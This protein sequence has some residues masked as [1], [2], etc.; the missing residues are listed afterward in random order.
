MLVNIQGNLVQT[1]STQFIPEARRGGGGGVVVITLK[2]LPTSIQYCTSIIRTAPTTWRETTS[3]VTGCL[4]QKKKVKEKQNIKTEKKT[5]CDSG[6]ARF[7]PYDHTDNYV[8]TVATSSFI[9]NKRTLDITIQQKPPS[10]YSSDIDAQSFCARLGNHVA[11][12]GQGHPSACFTRKGK[13]REAVFL[14][15]DSKHICRV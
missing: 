3:V 14:R 9:S 1:C 15:A 10:F 7:V 11:G 13:T 2:T 4:T 12:S 8:Y 6:F 5:R